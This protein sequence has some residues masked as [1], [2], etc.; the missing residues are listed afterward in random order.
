MKK[1][2]FLMAMVILLSVTTTVYS[3]DKI[4][5]YQN[6]TTKVEIG[7]PPVDCSAENTSSP[8]VLSN[9]NNPCP[10]GVYC[11]WGNCGEYCCPWGYFYSNPC[12][13]LRVKSFNNDTETAIDESYNMTPS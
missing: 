11:N 5:G 12:D 13:C 2:S 3:D 4:K 9:N 10:G 8:I 6:E 1:I 7:V